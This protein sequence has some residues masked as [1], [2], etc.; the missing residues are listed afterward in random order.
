MIDKPLYMI[1]EV[2]LTTIDV[3]IS[4]TSCFY[5]SGSFEKQIYKGIFSKKTF[6]D[7]LLLLLESNPG[8]NEK[9]KRCF[10]YL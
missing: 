2:L 4:T 10:L 5:L 6:S 9:K 8:K 1:Q 3:S 7:Y